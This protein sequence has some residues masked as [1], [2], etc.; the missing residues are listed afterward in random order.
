[1]SKVF[2]ALKRAEMER[3]IARMEPPV[4]VPE[5]PRMEPGP[6]PDLQEAM[7]G[8]YQAMGAVL[9]DIPRKIVQFVGSRE[10]EGTSTIVKELARVSVQRMGKAVLVIDADKTRPI[11]HRLF[12]VSPTYCL[13]DVIKNGGSTEGVTCNS[14]NGNPSVGILSRENTSVCEL[15]DSWDAAGLFDAL[16]KQFELVLIDSPSVATS[17]DC[18]SICP[19]VDGVVLVVEAEKTRWPV[20]E[21]AKERIIKS[22][23]NVLG[24][25]LNKREFHIPEFIYRRL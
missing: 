3:G 11:Q 9:P 19:R 22:G 16:R 10:G 24:M 12:G 7:M 6:H 20:A 2:E 4:L 25:V 23:G 8:L 17:P 14:V 15:L 21:A 1:M 18:L 13:E 5:G